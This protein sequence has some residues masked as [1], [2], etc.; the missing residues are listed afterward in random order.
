MKG[1]GREKRSSHNIQYLMNCT[2]LII[3]VLSYGCRREG[4]ND[5]AKKK[6]KADTYG[7]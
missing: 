7:R 1:K 3:K 6:K 4:Q 5:I 2:F